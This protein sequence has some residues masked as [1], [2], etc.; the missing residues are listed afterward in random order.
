MLC[1]GDKGIGQTG[2][3][4]EVSPFQGGFQGFQGGIYAAMSQVILAR[5]LLRAEIAFTCSADL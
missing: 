4:H 2:F 5:L 1:L 3:G